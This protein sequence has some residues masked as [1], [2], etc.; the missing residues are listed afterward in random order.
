MGRVVFLTKMFRNSQRNDEIPITNNK[1]ENKSSI[2][3]NVGLLFAPIQ[4]SLTSG[5][6]NKGFER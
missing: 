6:S 1:G 4:Y 5:E 2:S 3:P